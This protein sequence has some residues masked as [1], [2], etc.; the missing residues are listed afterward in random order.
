MG[1]TRLMGSLEGCTAQLHPGR[2]PSRAA[3]GAATS[4]V[5]EIE[6]RSQQQREGAPYFF[7]LLASILIVGSSILVENAVVTSNGFSMPRYVW[8]SS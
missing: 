5:T 1:A 7:T 2:R 4:R 8:T 6:L 3:K